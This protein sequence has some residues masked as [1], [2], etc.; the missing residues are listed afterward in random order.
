MFFIGVYV[1]IAS[2]V[3]VVFDRRLWVVKYNLSDWFW[4]RWVWCRADSRMSSVVVPV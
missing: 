4:S 3:Y 1:P 2:R